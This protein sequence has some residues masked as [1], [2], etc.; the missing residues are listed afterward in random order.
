M[1]LLTMKNID[2]SFFGKFANQ[3]V[4]L[5]VEAGEVHV[6]LGENGAGKTTLMNI[7]YGIYTK[8]AGEIYYDGRPVEFRSPKEA[9]A[10]KIGMVHQHFMLVP[11]LT[12]SQNIT[13][14][15]REKGY[16]CSNRKQLNQK[17]TQISRQYGLA[18]EP[19]A[20]VNTLSV[21][22]QQRVEIMK[23]LYRDAGLL[24]LDEPTAVL[25]PQ[26][27]KSF[28]RVLKKLREDGRSVILIT[29]HIPEVMDIADQVTVLRDTRS[30]I[31]API[32][33]MTEEKLSEFM[34]G[35]QLKPIERPTNTTR[36][37]SGLEVR[38]LKMSRKGVARLNGVSFCVAPGEILGIAGVDGNGQ[39]ELV[40][41]IMGIEKTSGGSVL[42]NGEDLKDKPIRS[43]IRRGLGYISADRQQDE[44]L[45][46]MNLAENMLLKMYEDKTMNRR[47]IINKKTLN[48]KTKAVIKDYD[49]K[50]YSLEI[51]IRL[52]SGGNQQKLV[53]A[54]ELAKE[55]G[56]LVVSQPTRGL[57]IGASEFIRE[58][59]LAGKKNGCSILLISADLEEIL[60]LSDRIAVI[61]G[62]KIMGIV[63][64]TNEVDMTAMGLMMAGRDSMAEQ[65]EGGGAG[66]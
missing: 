40:E 8:D 14:G 18:I 4:N 34:I 42:L 47:G 1:P 24:I 64:N 45:M 19:D 5:N 26:E 27:T 60:A 36:E 9:I 57:D 13:L 2:K 17:I 33:E 58:Q 49:I 50:T 39:K 55:P 51:P 52:L 28:F 15:L 62:G 43:R 35:R 56:A 16:P 3:K 65:E 66:E 32:A 21:G 30:I 20:R 25:T 54:R 53:L 41:A 61:H 38:D 44:L 6:L 46:D 37:G 12:V 7:L 11:T 31:T 63:P 59:L 10:H 29:H 48:A 23:L 22:E